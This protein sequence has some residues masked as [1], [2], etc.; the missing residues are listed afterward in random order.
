MNENVNIQPLLSR[1]RISLII[2]T[3]AYFG[4]LGII[5]WA[6]LTEATGSVS[7]W[8]VQAVPLLLALPWMIARKPK[9]FIW[10]SY[11][12]IMYFIGGVL[13]VANQHSTLLD[14]A[15]LSCAVIIVITGG[16]SSRFLQRYQNAV[17]SEAQQDEFI[18]E[19][20]GQ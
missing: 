9:A 18:E 12:T 19:H 16:F 15:F 1:L 2:L 5:T 7:R 14:A 8:V 20:H 4:I 13:A 3:T 10:L 6:N 11:L 17:S